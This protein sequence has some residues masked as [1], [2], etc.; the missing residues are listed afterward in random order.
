[1][2][3]HT[4]LTLTE[5]AELVASYGIGRANAIK[6]VAEGVENTNYIVQV[7]GPNGTTDEYFL[8]LY[9]EIEG[10]ELGFYFA[11][12]AH[13]RQSAL[14]VAAPLPNLEGASVLSLRD[15]PAALFPRL[16]GNHPQPIAGSHCRAMGRVLGS[17][18]VASMGFAQAHA[19]PRSAA[20][21][22]A[23]CNQLAPE[24]A[25][26]SQALLQQGLD[27]CQRVVEANMPS[28]PI[29]GDLFPDNT[30]FIGDRLTG[31]VDFVSGGNG[32]PLYDLAV[33]ANAW[34]AGTSGA[35][36]PLLLAPLLEAYQLERPI[37]GEEA[38]HWPDCLAMAGLRFWVSR[39]IA[40]A[41]PAENSGLVAVKN[42]EVYRQIL[43]AQLE[44]P[45]LW[46][47]N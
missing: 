12:L 47:G 37:D 23:A 39:Q 11:W 43:Q 34:C 16:P 7:T 9:E 19:G 31:L 6:A 36:L 26:D 46:P 30:L 45:S 10:H 44:N 1:M 17:L 8:T 20:W 41:G 3:V 40:A 15:K 2:A 14:P 4:E 28:I 24:L 32:A 35:L 33:V 27:A 13:L 42:P 5:I 25:Q 21:L 18:H 38:R 22:V 29:H